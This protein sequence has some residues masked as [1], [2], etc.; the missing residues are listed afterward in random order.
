MLIGGPARCKQK[1]FSAE[2]A[3]TLQDT[4]KPI[5][6]RWM[7]QDGNKQLCKSSNKA[8]FDRPQRK[9]YQETMREKRIIKG[10]FQTSWF[11]SILTL[12]RIPVKEPS[13]AHHLNQFNQFCDQPVCLGLGLDPQRL[14]S[15]SDTYG[16]GANHQDNSWLLTLTICYT[17]I[18]SLCARAGSMCCA[19]PCTDATRVRHSV[20]YPVITK[21]HCGLKC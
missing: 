16:A 13:N 10:D 1:H 3:Q 17:S 20:T 15:V 5:E 18:M 21:T 8:C 14:A 4:S 2:R 11:Q 6:S 12:A 9:T 7:G 19:P